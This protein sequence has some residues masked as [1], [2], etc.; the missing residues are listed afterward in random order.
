MTLL[1][2]SNLS[3]ALLGKT[4]ETQITEYFAAK[5]AQSLVQELTDEDAGFR[6]YADKSG[7]HKKARRSYRYYYGRHF[8][9]QQGVSDSE[10]LRG[11]DRGEYAMFALNHYR[12][13]IKNTLVLTTHEKP[14]FNPKAI[15][16]DP[17]SIQQARL[18]KGIVE[19]YWNEKQ[20]G[21]YAKNA[22]EM[23]QVMGKS[24]LC[25]LWN[26]NLGKPHDVAP[27]TGEDGAPVMDETGQPKERLI[28][29]GD[30][31]VSVKSLYDVRMD[32]SAE[33]FSKIQWVK[34]TGY[35]NKFD[36]A[37]QYPHLADKIVKLPTRS[38]S[39]HFNYI[40]MSESRKTADVAKHYFIHK[41]TRSMP[42][43]RLVIFCDKDTVLYDGPSPYEDKIPLFRIVPGEL[44][45]TTEGY[46]DFFD[47]MAIQEAID[48]LVSTYF[49]NEQAHGIQKIWAPEN[50][51][52]TS[53]QIS[54]GLA[55]LKSA[56]GTK[57]EPLQLSATSK[58]T[59]EGIPMLTK[60]METLS[61]VNSVA[62]GDPEHSL[63]SG[64][65]IAYVEAMAARYTSAF[66]QSWAEM[67][68]D[69][70]S[71]II[72]LLQRFA[73]TQRLIA[74]SGKHNKNVM[75]EFT[76]K[77]IK[78]VRRISV[79]L[80]NPITNTVSGRLEVAQN[81]LQ[82]G[83]LQTPQQYLEIL[84][85]G[86][87][88]TA[89]EASEAQLALIRKENDALLD[90]KKCLA[91]PGDKHVRHMQEHLSI[92]SDPELR[93]KAANG[94]QMAE[95]LLT[96]VLDHVQDH[97]QKYQSQAPI[98]SMISG[99][100]PPPPPPQPPGPPQGSGPAPGG[101]GGP[102]PAQVQ[103][104]PGPPG[105]MGQSPFMGPGPG[106][107]MPHHGPN[108]PPISALMAAPNQVPTDI[109]RLPPNLQPGARPQR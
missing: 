4:G 66:Q 92:A 68:E 9:G 3:G 77:D 50:C 82:Q 35:E 87:L 101:P 13:L 74:I 47:L 12:N 97:M 61:G 85:S 96:N 94:D 73:S 52:L 42:N 83:M 107:P 20:V 65:A 5:D 102:G 90:G 6:A 1:A 43:G 100:P 91:A 22:A 29:E 99:E 75:T 23:S 2:C 17:D 106:H 24:F 58:T 46:S 45:G 80:G 88:E 44:M 71:F 11:G 78:N 109:K 81:L 67:L 37:E 54:K 14:A 89:L 84:A 104:I 108:V 95:Q 60:A 7:L 39:E 33:D 70:A 21:R 26:P 48:V 34:I 25:V 49:T 93:I 57:P 10:I 59:L 18:S 8:F 40:A 69:V 105:P 27:V 55:L 76:K 56:P 53:T 64:V 41:Q 72:W 38:E 36:L 103:S 51:N 98:W 15:N 28:Y 63:K 79:E 31:E 86:N 16:T 32:T 19:Y 62:R 30:V